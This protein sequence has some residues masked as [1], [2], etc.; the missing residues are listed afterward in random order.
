MIV[1]MLS[2]FLIFRTD[3]YATR[4]SI[5]VKNFEFSPSNLPSV[6]IGDTIH[7]EWKNG[8]HTT[9]STAIPAGAAT[10]DNQLDESHLSFDYIPTVVGVYHYKCTPHESMGMVGQFTV[11]NL[12]G[13][14]ENVQVPKISI[15]PNPV[16]D[17][18]YLNCIV[19][20]G[21]FMQRL[22]IYDASGK[23]I[24]ETTFKGRNS[25]PDFLDLS[26]IP[27]GFIVFNF[28]DNLNRSY[29]LRALR[30]D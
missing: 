29:I 18:V 12:T 10:W 1:L 17:K 11:Q 19:P 9:T 24:R 2:F 25:F 3:S 26:D 30:K 8:S 4:Y 6:R 13:I 20:E 7:W 27:E 22:T 5:D 16:R 14:G 21:V 28:I 23:I 15:Y